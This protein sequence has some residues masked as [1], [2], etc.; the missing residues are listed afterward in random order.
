[1]HLPNDGKHIFASNSVNFQI[2]SVVQ[3][4]PYRS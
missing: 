2:I 4:I 1:M 3:E